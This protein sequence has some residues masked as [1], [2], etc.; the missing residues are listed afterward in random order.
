[1]SEQEKYELSIGRVY[2]MLE[3]VRDVPGTAGRVWHARMMVVVEEKLGMSGKF[4]DVDLG[5]QKV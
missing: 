3:Y 5:R 1:M 4:G 2:P